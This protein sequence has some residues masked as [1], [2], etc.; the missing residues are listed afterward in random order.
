MGAGLLSLVAAGVLLVL[1][2]TGNIGTKGYTGPGTTVDIGN[3][4]DAL[5]PLPSPTIALPPGDD[6]PIAQ[7]VIPKYEVDAPVQVKGVDA[8]NVMQ[9]PDGPTHVAWYDFSAKPG[10]GGNAVFSGH[11]DYINYGAAVFWHIKD[12]VPGD[13]IEVHLQDG[14]VY[15]YAVSAIN[16]VSADPTEA[17]LRDIV[18]P[19]KTDIVTLITCGGVFSQETHQ[20]DHRTIV[21]ATRVLEPASARAS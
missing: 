3:I 20:Y 8:N 10:F 2:V 4:K 19:S 7:L 11:V 16:Y 9:S 1:T 13:M 21:R 12:L 17:E 18:G 6:A 5:T 15:K 14:T